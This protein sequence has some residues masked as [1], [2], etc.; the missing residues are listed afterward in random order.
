MKTIIKPPKDKEFDADIMVYLEEKEDYEAKDYINIIYNLFKD[1]RKYEEIVGRK[2]RCITINYSGDFHVDIVPCIERNNVKY[3][4]NR[5]AKQDT[6]QFEKTDGTEYK[7]WF[8]KKDEQTK[9][10]LK[11]VT[12]LIKYLRDIKQTFTCKSILLTTLLANQ[13]NDNHTFSDLPTALKDIMVQLNNFLQAN[14]KMPIINNPV[15]KEEDFNR[16][17]NQENYDNFRKHI[18]TYTEKIQDAFEETDRDKSI[19]KWQHIFSD[20]FDPPQNRKSH[21]KYPC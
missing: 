10:Y 11:E 9:G 13:I 19:N 4:C 16:H 3:V 1:N 2:S 6:S 21:I 17:W 15:L 8:N 5:N 7:E 18:N 14:E 20:K 12:R